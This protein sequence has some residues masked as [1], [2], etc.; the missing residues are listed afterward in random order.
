MTL[1][2]SSSERAAHEAW[3]QERE[4]AWTS[5]FPDS[6]SRL[7]VGTQENR[8]EALVLFFHRRMNAPR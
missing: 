1:D 6:L 7:V 2:G 8:L 4:T 5:L 3:R